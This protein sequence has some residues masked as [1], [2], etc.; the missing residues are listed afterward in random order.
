MKLC[1]LKEIGKDW[2]LYKRGY[3]C[4]K[5]N[6]LIKCLSSIYIG[7]EIVGKNIFVI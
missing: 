2:F 3:G 7:E 4:F 6:Y 1:L 5:L